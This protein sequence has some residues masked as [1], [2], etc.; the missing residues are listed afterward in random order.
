[1]LSEVVL[2]LVDR[3]RWL[4][5]VGDVLGQVAGAAFDHLGPL[6]KP[7]E[8]VLH[9]TPFG[10]PVHPAIIPV[11]IGA[12]TTALALDLAGNEDGADLAVDLGLVGAISAAVAGLA[13]WRYTEGTQRR[14]GVAHALLNI[15]GTTLYALSSFRRHSGN[16]AGA[17][18]LSGLGYLCVVGGGYVGG[19]LAYALGTMVNRNA[20][21][22]GSSP[23]T[24]VMPLV[25]LPDSEPT[26]ATVDGEDVVLVRRGETVYALRHSCSHLGGPLSEGKL[27]GD[28]IVCP[29]HG[30]RFNLEDGRVLDGPAA[31]HQPC[32]AARVRNG[33]VEIQLAG[34]FGEHE[35][36][37]RVRGEAPKE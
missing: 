33:L 34:E 15:A 25:D 5:R 20:W 30:S 3:Q 9:G 29:W 35:P 8:D 24:P 14:A 12:W 26:R 36:W 17:K 16:R 4:D 22:T 21:V 7:L 6:S 13:D 10:H 19:D 31:Y 28:T 27:E 11:P 18:T 2:R 23:Y 37:Y 1:M 32:Y